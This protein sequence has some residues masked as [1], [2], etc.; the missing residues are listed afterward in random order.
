M[1]ERCANCDVQLNPVF[2]DD[3]DQ[4]KQYDNAL[5]IHLHGGYG[6]FFDDFVDRTVV[7]LCHDCGHEACSLLPWLDQLIQPSVSHAHSAKF[8]KDNLDHIGWDSP[9]NKKDV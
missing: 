2:P 4:F 7:F 9:N 5:E 1:T 3:K 6:M 8:W